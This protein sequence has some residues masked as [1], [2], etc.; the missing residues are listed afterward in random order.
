MTNKG[1]YTYNEV[2]KETD[3]LSKAVMS[4]FMNN[5]IM[6][7]WYDCGNTFCCVDRRK[8]NK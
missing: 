1:K 4:L 7:H 6:V 8:E 3:F 5:N 2:L